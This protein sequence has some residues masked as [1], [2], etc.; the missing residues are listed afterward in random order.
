MSLLSSTEPKNVFRFFEEI[1]AIPR[2]SGNMK[3][4]SEY[5]VNFAKKHSLDYYTDSADNVIIYKQATKG[6]E[7]S[8]PVILQGHLDMVCQR[9][10]S[11]NIDFLNDGLELLLDGDFVKAN[12][13]TLGADNGIAVSMILAILASDDIAHPP[14]EAVFTTDE[15]IGLLGAGALDMSK[16]SAKKMINLDAEEDG[17]LTV[18]CAGGSDLKAFLPF[19]CVAVKG[20][21]VKITLGG[22][23]GGHSGVEIDKGRVN[24]NV[25]AGRFLNSINAYS[26]FDIIKINGGDK[27]NAITKSCV[28]EFC[29]KDAKSFIAL[30]EKQLN[31]IREE[32]LDREPDFYF[33]FSAESCEICSVIDEKSKNA[34]IYC[35]LLAPDGIQEMS[36]EIEGLVQTSLNLGALI[37]NEKS[38][39]FNFALRSNKKSAL[40]FLEQKVTTLFENNGCRV[41][42]S[43]KYPPWEY[44]GDSELQT[45]FKNCYE[46]LFNEEPKVEA[47]HA[48]LEC[49]MFSDAIKGI[50]CVAFGPTMYDVHT[51]DERL[52]ISSTV[53]IYK[54]L[55]KIL[56]SLK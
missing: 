7:N 23:I 9:T 16:L 25:L 38:I 39:M 29:V 33:D 5:C 56:E 35:L 10:E 45:V 42:V 17:V 22:M 15:E 48:G 46:A 6:F 40:E 49:A 21:K 51:V 27:S 52:S 1:S 47:I 20:E 50:D 53:R 37:T 24:A 30:A 2:G 4:I 54:L 8:K 18:S 12:G 19:E 11:S 34:L 55:L 3:K 26:D 41:E 36:A 28:I 14:I 31:I 43:G 13:T 32:I 44:M